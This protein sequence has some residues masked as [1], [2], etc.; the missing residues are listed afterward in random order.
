MI[1]N[2]HIQA[3]ADALVHARRDRTVWSP[4]F[5]Q[6]LSIEEAYAVQDRVASALGWFAARRPAAWKAG[7]PDRLTE[8][9]AAPLPSVRE[10]GVRWPCTGQHALSVE[11]EVAVRFGRTPST[12]VD[13]I[14]CIDTMCVSIEI[15]ATRL[16]DG[17][18]APAAWKLADQQLHA[19]LVIGAE[20][21]FTARDWSSQRCSLSINGKVQLAVQGAHPCGDP[22]F[23]LAWLAQH[24]R[25]CGDGLRAGD[26]VTTGSWTGITPVQPGDRVVA[27]FDGIGEAVVELVP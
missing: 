1:L 8:P 24:A 17:L 13:I 4:D 23:S 14:D 22:L 11:A 6:P 5:S 18:H 19:D 27:R 3:I 9:T 16:A 15:V 20:V 21:P 26:L 10:S 12:S 25:R 7:G 2:S